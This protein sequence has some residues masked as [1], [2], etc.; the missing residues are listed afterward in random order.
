[1]F[2]FGAL[3]PEINSGRIYSGPGSAPMI[4]AASAW[5]GVAAELSSAAS[6][7]NSVITELT[8]S[9]WLGPASQAMLAAVV[10][11]VGWLSAAAAQAEET[12]TQARAA[13][14]AYDAAFSMTVPPPVIAA[15]R[16]LLMTLVATNFFGQNTPAIATTEAH[17]I[18]MW[19]QDAAAMY[20]YA[21]S[22][23]IATELARFVAPPNT[24]TPDGV[25][26]QAAAVS[27]AA[28]T[29][30]AEAQTTATQLVS[31]AAV[32]QALQ[33][34]AAA[35]AAAVEPNFVWNTIQNFMMYGLPTPANNYLGLTPANYTTMVRALQLY[36][37][38]GLAAFGTQIQQQLFNGLGTTAGASGAWYPTP[39]FAALGAGGWHFHSGASL[40]SASIS[41]ASSGKIGGLSVPVSWTNSV[42]T[43]EGA[44]AK[45]V[46]AN[47]AA[48]STHAS[49]ASAMHS[50]AGIPHAARSAQ[51]AGNMGVRYGFRYNVVTRPP[52]AG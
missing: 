12:G 19:A 35:P 23:A 29:P 45:V 50:G 10:P 14:A 16:A 40:S 32:P 39:Q 46:S 47:F 11:Y 41:I 42:G 36:F 6:G 25:P 38:V 5:D 9:P 26:A 34:L 4:A 37:G 3:P 33:Q 51:R 30:A 15:N 49:P 8:G 31:T 1:M 44:G 17:Y 52:S 2:D 48:T 22:S 18:E 7:Y 21:A 43:V 20:E 24:T 27:H 28:A 13:A